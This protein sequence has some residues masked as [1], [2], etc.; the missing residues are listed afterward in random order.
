[1]RLTVSAFFLA[2]GFA[3]PA[4][5]QQTAP[6][7]VPVG[8]VTAEKKPI[9]PSFEFVGR[10]E[11]INRVEIRARVTGFLEEVL[12]KEGGTVNEGTP[13]Y[14][15]EK[16][17]FEAAVKQAQG[18]LERAKAA[19]VLTEIQLK[20]AE[21]LLTTSSGTV[22]A[23]DQALAADEQASG[24]ILEAQANLLTA[25]IN[26]GYTDITSPIS[27]KIGRTILTKG[28]VV[29]PQTGTLTTIVSQDP[30][31]VTFPVSQR[32][33][34]RARQSGERPALNSFKVKLRYADGTFYDQ[35]GEVNFVDV[36]VDRATD[37]VTAR[38]TV[39][40]PTAGLIDG[41]LMTVVVELGTSQ[42]KVVIPQS[43]LLADQGG[44]YVFVVEDGKAVV[45]RVKTGGPS[46]TGMV[47][48][49]GLTGGE[50][51]V[52]EGLQSIRPGAPV[53]AAPVT[54]AG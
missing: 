19:K 17:L 28:N 54:T 2:F 6:A 31:Y 41:Q 30:M 53:R 46:G 4:Y 32:D 21:E 10:V 40:N 52:V 37:T 5:G 22:V 27:G 20:R 3:L 45:K 9:T 51:V 11:A 34:L 35:I 8:V 44:V 49:S 36:T 47:I 25:Q 33:F 29:S 23:R 43:A 14:R 16:G 1:M 24:S 42:Q 48:D 39:A 15:I 38:A 7:T 50:L 26:L 18:A 13:L 12:F